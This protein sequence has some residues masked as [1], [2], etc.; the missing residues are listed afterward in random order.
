MRLENHI[1]VASIFFSILGDVVQHLDE[2]WYNIEIPNPE[3]YGLL[4]LQGS[5]FIEALHLAGELHPKSFLGW[6]PSMVWKPS[7][8]QAHIWEVLDL[9]AAAGGKGTKQ[10]KSAAKEEKSA[11]FILELPLE[12][13]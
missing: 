5:I 10:A 7:L 13:W 1:L 12:V 8:Q 9:T 3:P 2:D 6:F 4:T 11:L